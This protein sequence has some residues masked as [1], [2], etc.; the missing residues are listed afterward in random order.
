MA[1][2][3]VEITLPNGAIALARVS[4]LGGGAEKTAAI[5]RLDFA[6]FAEVLE[7][8]TTS[9]KEALDRAAPD[10][11]SVTMELELALK[12]GKLSGLLVDGEGKGS[13]GITLEWQRET[14]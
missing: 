12:S 9:L 5:P 13:V 11:V 10:K 14:G 8:I 6:D 3:V 7:G 1:D 4:R 2:Q